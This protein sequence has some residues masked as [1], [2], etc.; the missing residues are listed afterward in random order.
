[1]AGVHKGQGI[2]SCSGR[3]RVAFWIERDFRKDPGLENAKNFE[4]KVD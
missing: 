4:G 3:Q 1:M 2:R